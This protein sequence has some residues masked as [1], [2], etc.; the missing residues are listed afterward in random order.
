MK[1]ISAILLC[2]LLALCVSSC[3]NENYSADTESAKTV[4]VACLKGPTGVGMTK[5]MKDNDEKNTANNYEFTVAAA[6]DEISGKIV[7][8]EIN[9]ASV[10]TN[11]AVKLYNKTGGKIRMLAVNTLGVL[12]IVENGNTI[13]SVADLNGKTVYLTGEGSN[14]EYII[15]YVIEKNGLIVGKDVKLAFTASNDELIA[16]L[17]SGKATVAMIPEPAATTALKKLNTLVRALDINEEWNKISDGSL[18]MG[19]AVTTEAFIK[20]NPDAVKNFLSDYEKSVKFVSDDQDKTA[21]LCETYG[22]IPS[23]AVA[24]SA[25]NGCNICFITGNEMKEGISGYF[26]VLFNA[27]KEFLGGALPDGDFYYGTK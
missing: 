6:A 12:H 21:S 8:G 9:I 16:A 15:K 22:I 18:M 1:K 4:T 26:S 3:G 13:K 14:P 11:L 20:K 24:K 23:A 7:T 5:L 10:P 27:N 2:I 19:C 25:I 17:I